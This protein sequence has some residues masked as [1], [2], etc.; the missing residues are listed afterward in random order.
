MG[1]QNSPAASQLSTSQL[2]RRQQSVNSPYGAPSAR[3]SA[4]CSSPDATTPHAKPSSSAPVSS[5]S[6]EPC[7]ASSNPPRSSPDSLPPAANPQQ[8]FAESLCSCS[9]D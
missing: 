3:A 1:S 5:P 8:P 7:P 4:L 2:N 9:S 6:T